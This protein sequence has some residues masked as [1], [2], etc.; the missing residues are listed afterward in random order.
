[1]GLR[2][3][4]ALLLLGGTLVCAEAVAQASLIIVAGE[5][6]PYVSERREQ[7]FLSDLFD[8]IGKQMGLRFEFR[9]MPWKR[10]ELAVEALQAWGAVPYVPTP[11]RERK[12]LFSEPLYAKRT[13]FFYYSP[14]GPRPQISFSELSDLKP[15]R[16]GGVRGYY[17][18][19]MFAD[20]GLQAEFAIGEEQSFGK[21]RAGRVD[22]VPAVEAV[23]RD[24]IKKLF[25]LEEQAHFH[26][27][28]RPMHVG[29]NFLMSSRLYPGNP[30]DTGLLARFNKALAELRRNGVYN[31]VAARHGLS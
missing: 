12:H 14:G 25:P 13:M 4:E 3:R 16:L 26:M 18:E 20:A 21:L 30:G 9:F 1:M 31:A 17:Y 24:M 7:S 10:C 29:F 22:L 28:D 2:R 8:E 27:L 5:L 19:K 11:E 15:Y 23:G 6:P